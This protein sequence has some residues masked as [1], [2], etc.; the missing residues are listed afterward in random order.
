MCASAFGL[1]AGVAA[2]AIPSSV[3]PLAAT[4]T[5]DS[6]HAARGHLQGT[7]PNLPASPKGLNAAS[8]TTTADSYNWSGY[9]D[10]STTDQ[11]FSKVQSSWTVTPV[12]CTPEDRIVAAWVG[13]DGLSNTTVEQVG[14]SAQCYEGSA[15]YF[16]WWDMFPSGTVTVGTT[17]QPGDKITASVTRTGTSYA[18][19]LT[20]A[21]TSGNNVHI[22]K[23]CALTTCTD[24]SAEVIVER[25]G[26]AT[27]GIAPLA[28]FNPMSFTGTTVTGGGTA[29]SISSFTDEAIEIL[30]STSAYTLNTTGAL[31][32]AGK[33]FSDTWSNSY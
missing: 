21:T 9:A 18:L 26:F 20:D 27:T 8:A 32:P 2:I 17:V 29:G 5:V 19:A 22:M 12:T 15:V 13:L 23:T 1:G 31:N 16:S 10:T 3:A 25:P 28:Q 33:G 4:H 7:G 11:F 30:D 24:T 14:V 6:T